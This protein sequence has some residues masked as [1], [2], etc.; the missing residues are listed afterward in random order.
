MPK[1]VEGELKAGDARFAIVSSRFNE[2]V[3]DRLL[4]G[5][6]ETL[7][8]HGAADDAITVYR[9][10]GA[11]EIPVVAERVAMEGEFDAII[12]VGAVI[13]G[14]TP[15]FEYISAEVTR[16]IGEV[17]LTHEI[18]VTFGLITADKVEHAVQRAGGDAGNKGAEAA[19][20]AIETVQVLRQVGA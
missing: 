6:V 9:V 17:A 18:P 5:A 16:G 12:C 2:F 3:T 20:A 10:P 8:S 7:R 19:L 11:F 1:I 4:E 13:R 14:E 15:H